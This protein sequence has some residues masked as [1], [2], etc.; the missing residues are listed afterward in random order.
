M[1]RNLK[2]TNNR[3]FRIAVILALALMAAVSLCAGAKNAFYY[4]QDF[5]WDAAKALMLKADPYELSINPEKVY[6]YDELAEFYRLFTDMG[7]KQKMEANQFPS[8]LMLLFPYALMPPF[9][10][11][12]VWLISNVLFTAG[13]AFCLKKTFL[14]ELSGFEFAAVIL[15]MIAGTPY[16][17]Q[18]G[19]G[20]HTLFSFF[21]FL[22]A[23]YLEER[24]ENTNDNKQKIWL[25]AG[26]VLCL[27]ISF[28]K[29]TLTAPLALY[30]VYKKKFKELILSVVLH[31]VLT[32]TAALMLG[33]SVI[34][35]ITA[36]LK[37]AMNLSSE[38]GLDIGALVG[39]GTLSLVIAAIIGI[40]LLVLC[41]T[42]Q[43]GYEKLL[44]PVLI[45]WSLIMT[46][47]RTYDFFVL[48]AVVM[49][50]TTDGDS[51]REKY[52]GFDK[53][54]FGFYPVL[55]LAVYFGL[56]VFNE[57]T[58]S[59]VVVGALYYAFTIACTYNLTVKIRHNKL[60]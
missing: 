30:F 18:I 32:I 59:R 5:Q 52:S 37:V 31:G 43:S 9:A 42:L 4:S 56:R 16:R 38:G 36:P 7:L 15:L 26:I 10:A 55:I 28:F 58:F 39:G 11:R 12:I 3:I 25:Q 2:I 6:E 48:S 47:H 24:E 41:V 54:L 27:F 50:F 29:Y 17:N 46:Y 14:K 40:F 51:E 45:L 21:F 8:L 20:Q 13:I 57:N 23:V 35:M 22:L 1:L 34:Y 49:M 33:K 60:T 44:V 53:F 19:V